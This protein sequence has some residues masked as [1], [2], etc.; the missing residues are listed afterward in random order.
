M[1]IQF[2]NINN[3]L[4]FFDFDRTLVAHTYS[5]E[6][7][8][9]RT[10]NY[11]M[12]CV[13]CLTALM[14]EHAMDKPLP[15]MQWYAKKLFDDGYGL[16]VLTH[17]VFNLRDQLKKEQLK[18]FYPDTPMTYLTVD[19][20]EHKVDMM[21]AIAA[22]E[23]CDLSDVIF[24]DDKMETVQMAQTAG[25]DAKHLSDIVTLY[26]CRVTSQ[27]QNVFIKPKGFADFLNEDPTLSEK[28]THEHTDGINTGFSDD[29]LEK[30]YE[31]CR[32]IVDKEKKGDTIL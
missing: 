31:E 17:E 9:V 27:Q 14:E 10:G 23:G 22:I 20:P 25:I 24:I 8:K 32:K 19:K 29:E 21:M 1:D 11:F 2:P 30:A 18:L 13:Y 3:K 7:A 26:E 15:C 4:A 6:Y 16:Y 5:K 28:I 12:E